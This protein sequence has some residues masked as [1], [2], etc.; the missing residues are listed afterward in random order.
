MKAALEKPRKTLICKYVGRGQRETVSIFL[1]LLR[2]SKV[3]SD[4]TLIK[5]FFLEKKG[6]VRV[7]VSPINLSLRILPFFLI[8]SNYFAV[9]FPTVIICKPL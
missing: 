6:S 4:F 9:Y 7:L 2:Q 8:V 3:Y 1:S 5:I